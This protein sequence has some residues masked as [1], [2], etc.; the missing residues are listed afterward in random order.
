MGLASETSQIAGFRP[1]INFLGLDGSADGRSREVM[2]IGIALPAQ[3]CVGVSHFSRINQA[4]TK[5]HVFTVPYAK[6]FG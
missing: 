5:V 1:K 6:V 2:L 4:K 3:R